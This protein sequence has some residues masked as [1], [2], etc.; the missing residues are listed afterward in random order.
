MGF[1]DVTCFVSWGWGKKG[2]GVGWFSLF[3]GLFEA[4]GP[5]IRFIIDCAPRGLNHL[6]TFV[7]SFPK[8][9]RGALQ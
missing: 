8:G 1:S 2:G 6:Q 5:F 9:S 7:G 3:P 4:D